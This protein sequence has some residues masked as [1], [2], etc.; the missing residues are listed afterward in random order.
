MPATAPPDGADVR[1]VLGR[2]ARS[3][4][5]CLVAYGSMWLPVDQ[6]P[7]WEQYRQSGAPGPRP[8]NPVS[9]PGGGDGTDSDRKTLS[10]S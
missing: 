10:A 4:W 1:V 8:V 7:F 9:V 5:T 3:V 2:L 6:N